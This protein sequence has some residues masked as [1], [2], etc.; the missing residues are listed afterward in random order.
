MQIDLDQA[1]SAYQN[2]SEQERELIREAMDSPLASVL[3]KVF[4]DLMSALGSFNK[5]RRKMDAA[6]RR[7]AAGMLMR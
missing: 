3:S 4:P 6:Q 7:M 1:Q 5:P 2:L